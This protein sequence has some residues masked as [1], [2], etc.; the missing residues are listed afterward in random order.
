VPTL[1]PIFRHSVSCRYQYCSWY[2]AAA[3]GREVSVGTSMNIGNV[4]PPRYHGM[5]PSRGTTTTIFPCRCVVVVVLLHA[6]A[7]LCTLAERMGNALRKQRTNILFF[8]FS[9]PPSPPPYLHCSIIIYPRHGSRTPPNLEL[10]MEGLEKELRY[11]AVGSVGVDSGDDVMM[12]TV[13]YF[14]PTTSSLP[15]RWLVV[16]FDASLFSSLLFSSPTPL[17]SVLYIIQLHKLCVSIPS[18]LSPYL[19]VDMLLIEC[20]C[21]RLTV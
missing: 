21:V 2:I 12:M 19:A 7:I 16:V 15:N 17:S 20:V 1:L 8:C 14:L 13:Y 18:I 3:G 11:G 5:P 6:A 10:V 9:L 4:R